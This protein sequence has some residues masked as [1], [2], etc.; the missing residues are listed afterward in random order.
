MRLINKYKGV[1][2]GLA[3]LSINKYNMRAIKSGGPRQRQ[4]PVI[5][6]VS[7]DRAYG[8]VQIITLGGQRAGAANVS[9]RNEQGN[10]GA[11][12]ALAL[13]L[14]VSS[15]QSQFKANQIIKYC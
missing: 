6:E 14:R 3:R 15:S 8:N 11:A 5:H 10:L 7:S 2:K 12:H 13:A 9:F 4:T 1:K